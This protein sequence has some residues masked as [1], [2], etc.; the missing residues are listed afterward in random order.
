MSR[1]SASAILTIIGVAILLLPLVIR[2]WRD[3]A[4]EA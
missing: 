1:A 3:R 2:T 4:Q